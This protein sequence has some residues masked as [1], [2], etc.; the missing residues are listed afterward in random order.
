VE[1]QR[2]NE[3]AL[4]K[5]QEENI[6]TQSDDSNE[7]IQHIKNLKRDQKSH[8][9]IIV[10]KKRYQQFLETQDLIQRTPRKFDQILGKTGKGTR[11]HPD[12]FNV[13]HLNQPNGMKP[14]LTVFNHE[15][16]RDRELEV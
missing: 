6:E 9:E 8:Q 13:N 14:P 5:G 7:K 10:H 1:V 15:Q 12:Y 11:E 4:L 16:I 2:Q 3:L